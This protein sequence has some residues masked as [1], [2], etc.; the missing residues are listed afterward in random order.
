MTK[1]NILLPSGLYDLLPKDAE[2]EQKTVNNLLNYFANFGYEQVSPPLMEFEETLLA[3][4]GSAVAGRTFR[5]LDPLSQTMLAVRSDITLQVARIASNLLVGQARPLRLCYAGQILQ[6]SDEILRSER[7]LT[8]VGIELIGSD[9][10]QADAETMIIAVKSLEKIGVDDISIDINLP[11]LLWQLSPEAESDADLQNRI[12]D[13]IASKNS[14]LV[15]ELPIENSKLIA[16]LIEVSGSLE[17]SIAL[18]KKH[19]IEVAGEVEELV[20]IVKQNC[21]SIQLTFD[22]LEY[23]GL[24]YHQGISFSLFCKGLRNELG[25][26]GRYLID[27]EA[28]TGFTLYITY[29]LPLLAD[30]EKANKILLPGNSDI[31]IVEKL[32]NQGFT[33]LYSLSGELEKEAASLNCPY[34]F[35]EGK[36]EKL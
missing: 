34:I 13:A 17:Q 21:P 2:K 16:K 25:R 36:I 29:L 7:Q 14:D 1:S 27:G 10:L 18:L 23:R 35:K 28:A 33:T 24:N 3:G 26:G 4:R 6:S 30:A 20:R 9:S 22:P 5:L 32:Q 12:K 11:A 8:Q 15:A 31:N 19:N